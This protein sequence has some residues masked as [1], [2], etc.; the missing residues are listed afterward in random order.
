MVTSQQGGLTSRSPCWTCLGRLGWRHHSKTC[1]GCFCCFPCLDFWTS[2]G[3]TVTF[4]RRTR[5]CAS[6]LIRVSPAEGGVWDIGGGRCG[7]ALP[8]TCTAPCTSSPQP[9]AGCMTLGPGTLCPR[10]AMPLACGRPAV[11]P[12]SCHEH[13]SGLEVPVGCT[14]SGSGMIGQH[15]E[16]D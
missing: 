5:G 14:A 12:F 8:A 6:T 7:A 13:Y 4:V 3:N 15:P 11:R 1:K 10:H 16:V 9:A 2:K